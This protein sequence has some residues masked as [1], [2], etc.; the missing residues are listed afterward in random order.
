M[1]RRKGQRRAADRP[2]VGGAVRPPPGPTR[3]P[4]RDDPAETVERLVSRR[5]LHVERGDIVITREP[6]PR[7]KPATAPM[8]QFRVS[9]Y[10]ALA[11]EGRVYTSFQHAA[12]EGELLATQQ[13]ARLL[14]V[15]D[16]A[17]TLLNDY[18]G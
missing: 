7:L 3:I 9:V 10:P 17:P 12:S 4:P 2:E 15:E 16:D 14:F 1:E 18:R 5:Q 6:V 11:G 8:W 13:R